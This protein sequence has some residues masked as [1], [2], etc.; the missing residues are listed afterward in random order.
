MTLSLPERTRIPPLERLK[1]TPAAKLK[2]AFSCIVSELIRT[3]ALTARAEPATLVSSI[4]SLA[5]TALREYSVESKKRMIEVE[6][7]AAAAALAVAKETTAAPPS[8]AVLVVSTKAQ[9][10]IALF[11]V[12]VAPV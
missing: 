1:L 10:K 6:V 3:L 7:V 11:V 2:P 9:G 5:V 8:E 12:P 4:L